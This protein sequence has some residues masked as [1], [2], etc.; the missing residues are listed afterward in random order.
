ME[1]TGS[2]KCGGFSLVEW[3]PGKEKILFPA[4]GWN[5]KHLPVGDGEYVFM[6]GVTDDEW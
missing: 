6:F 2:L 4:G 3:L 1:E 5:R